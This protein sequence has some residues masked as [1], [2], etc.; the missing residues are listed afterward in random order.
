M[1]IDEQLVEKVVRKAK[2]Y[3]FEKKYDD[4]IRNIIIKLKREYEI[5]AFGISSYINEKHN[6]KIPISSIYSIL[7]KEEK[8]AN[9]K[10][11]VKKVEQKVEQYPIYCKSPI[12]NDILEKS[13]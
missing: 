9:K 4:N 2:K 3:K 11:Q 10:T 1:K 12:K 8:N 6:I 5:T 13:E 7:R